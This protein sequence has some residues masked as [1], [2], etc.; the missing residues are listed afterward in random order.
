MECQLYAT[1]SDESRCCDVVSVHDWES[2]QVGDDHYLLA[3]VYSSPQSQYPST[4]STTM[5]SS[6]I[7]RW[8]GV[9]KFVVAH[10]LDTPPATDWET[11]TTDAGDVYL[12]CANGLAGI[13]QLFRV[14]LVY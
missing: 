1:N 14:K 10:R 6:V 12:V 9:E 7:Y 3:A 11:F 2:F 8:Q 4:A 5:T 13:S